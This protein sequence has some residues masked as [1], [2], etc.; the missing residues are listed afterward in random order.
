MGLEEV[1]LTVLYQGSEDNGT[2]QR[3]SSRDLL[4]RSKRKM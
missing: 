1:H 3:F 4:S 2:I